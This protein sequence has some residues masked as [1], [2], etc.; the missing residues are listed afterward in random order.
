M[1]FFAFSPLRTNH[2]G[3]MHYGVFYATKRTD[4]LLY[5]THTFMC[6]LHAQQSR[7][8]ARDKDRKAG[9]LVLSRKV[10]FLV[11]HVCS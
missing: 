9:R 2:H 5:S 4:C 1:H 6:L 3:T 7:P 11:L 10:P 8:P